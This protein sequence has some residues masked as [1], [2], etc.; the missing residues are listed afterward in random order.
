MLR[1][2]SVEGVARIGNVENVEGVASFESV[3]RECS[4]SKLSLHVGIVLASSELC[5]SV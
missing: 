2:L 3:E 4:M 1:V 5:H